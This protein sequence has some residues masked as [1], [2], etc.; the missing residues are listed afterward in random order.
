MPSTRPIHPSTFH[1]RPANLASSIDA[2]RLR[3]G[4]YVGHTGEESS[5]LTLLSCIEKLR[6]APPDGEHRWWLRRDKIG[7]HITLTYK[8][9]HHILAHLSHAHSLTQALFETDTG[10]DAVILNALSSALHIAHAGMRLSYRYGVLQSAH[11]VT[12]GDVM[13]GAA[14]LDLRID[15]SILSAGLTWRGMKQWAW[16]HASA[17]PALGLTLIHARTGERVVIHAPDGLASWLRTQTRAPILDVRVSDGG[18]NTLRLAAARLPTQRGQLGVWV[19]QRDV[20]SDRGALLRAI[21]ERITGRPA[22]M[23]RRS[24]CAPRGMAILGELYADGQIC[25]VI[26]QSGLGLINTTLLAP[27]LAA[28]DVALPRWRMAMAV[29]S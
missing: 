15:A 7:A 21:V 11:E 27:T 23:K 25:E 16:R 19:G 4:M 20:A 9:S 10:H 18:A 1:E 26:D 22:R 12:G 28:L 2:I 29:E 6:A 24:L 13:D 8:G 3:P 17:D 14:A 5:A